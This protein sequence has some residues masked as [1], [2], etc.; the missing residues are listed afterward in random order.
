MV[1]YLWEKKYQ[2]IRSPDINYR[3]LFCM[4][5]RYNMLLRDEDLRNLNLSDCFASI[6][7]KPRIQGLQQLVMLTF[8]LNKGKINL[9]N[10][11]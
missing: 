1:T 3:D 2:E 6:V 7:T 9:N 8:K 10:E 4:M 5:S 11:N